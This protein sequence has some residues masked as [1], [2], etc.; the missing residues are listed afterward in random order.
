[1][2][3]LTLSFSLFL[4]A[5]GV[6]HSDSVPADTGADESSS[7]GTYG[8]LPGNDEDD[9]TT[10][11]ED[12][13]SEDTDTVDTDVEDTDTDTDGGTVVADI[14]AYILIAPL[15]E[16]EESLDTSGYPTVYMY[17]TANVTDGDWTGYGDTAY[18]STTGGY[19]YDMETF[20]P[21]DVLETNAVW[22]NGYAWEFFADNGKTVRSQRVDWDG[23]GVSNDSDDIAVIIV[24]E[25]ETYDILPIDSTGTATGEGDAYLVESTWTDDDGS[26]HTGQDIYV[27]TI[28]HTTG[29]YEE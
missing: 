1:M 24:Y 29:D 7:G 3:S 13:D 14:S 21:G 2:R 18:T 5:C 27:H 28:N 26:V 8:T 19:T 16:W 23:D 17:E 6:D 20:T 22:W 10:D 9:T 4:A 25:D 15:A 11:T 12:T